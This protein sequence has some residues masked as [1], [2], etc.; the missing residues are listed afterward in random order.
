[1][2]SAGMRVRLCLRVRRFVC[3]NTWCER[4]TFVEQMAGLTRR[5]SRW[6]ERLRSM[7][8]AVGLALAGRAGANTMF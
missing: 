6:T 1:M 2:P 4:R 3:G 5:Y 8:A 7:L